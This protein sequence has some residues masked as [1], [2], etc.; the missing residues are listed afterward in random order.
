MDMHGHSRKQQ[1][2]VSYLGVLELEVESRARG[3]SDGL[4]V[5][6]A[7]ANLALEQG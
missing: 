1:P 4:C 3:N 6:V 5:L 7:I 2:G